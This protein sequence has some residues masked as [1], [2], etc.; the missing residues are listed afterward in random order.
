VNSGDRKRAQPVP[1]PPPLIEA[2][3]HKEVDFKFRGLNFRFALSQGLF[4]SADIDT[5]TRLLLKVLSNIWDEGIARGRPLPASVLDAG[6]GI[7]VIGV[8]AATALAALGNRA[9]GG[10]ALP[11]RVRSQ[12]RDEL[13]RVFTEYNARQNGVS[14]ALLSAH[15]EPLL[16]GPAGAAWDLIITNIPAKTG[17]PVLADFVSRSAALLNAGGRVLL[18]AVNPL[19][20]FFRTRIRAAAL[21]LYREEAGKGHT[22]LLYGPPAIKPAA[23]YPAPEGGKDLLSLV[24][25]Y[26]RG[27]GSYEMEGV[28]YSLETCYGA[29]SFDSPGGA[30]SAAVKL[31]ARLGPKNL[32]PPPGDSPRPAPALVHGEDQ[33]HFP[34]WLIKWIARENPGAAFPFRPLVLSGRNILA[35]EAGRHNTL[36]ALGTLSDGVI[37]RP[38]VDLSAPEEGAPP[39]PEAA[40]GGYPFIA[41]FPEPVPQT[42]RLG[43]YWEG[44]NRLLCPG[45]LVLAGLSASE[46]ERFDRKKLKNFTRLG[47]IKRKGFRAL[48]YRR[49]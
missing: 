13:A 26:L 25:A 14:P 10:G 28:S 24:P 20:D 43:A 29:A 34:L 17:E 32:L 9:L 47:D 30:V 5:G 16:A 41:L 3:T 18:V 37:I 12:D 40:G 23:A 44:L 45:G 19:A 38:A 31:L 6:S 21:P 48:A 35:L 39:Q 49:G 11:C 7:G 46:A 42:D 27:S 1:E 4:S 36:A 2:Y 15:T 8:C 22:V 33:G